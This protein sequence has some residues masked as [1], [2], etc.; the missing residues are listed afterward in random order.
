MASSRSSINSD[1]DND[2]NNEAEPTYDDLANAVEKHRTL[3]EKKNKKIR[4]HDDLVESLN[5]EI[6]RL[7]TL[8]PIDDNCKSYDLVYAEFTSLRDVHACVLKQLKGEKG[9]K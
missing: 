4:K 8:I 3:L 6:A 7:K 1:L 9:E 5:S 2:G